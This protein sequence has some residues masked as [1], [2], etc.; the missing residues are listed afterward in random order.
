MQLTKYLRVATPII[1]AVVTFTVLFASLF[2]E[3]PVSAESDETVYY[4]LTDH[5]GS[6]DVVLDEDGNVV[7]RRDYLPYGSARAEVK[8]PAAPDT[9]QG[10]TGKEL[11][12]ETGLQ[13]YGAR[14]YDP[15]I[16]R[17]VS[18]DPWEG[19]LK[20][21]QTF[22][23]FA[24]VRNNPVRYVDPTGEK[25][26]EYQPY[27]PDNG[28]YYALGE[29]MGEYRGITLYSS[30][31]KTGSGEH[32]YQCTSWAKTFALSEYGVDMSGTGNGDAYGQQSEVSRAFN[33][34]NPDNSNM[35]AVNPNG[36][37]V[38]PREDDIIS[39]SGGTY[40][41]VGVIVEV[42]FDAKS[43]TGQVYTLEQNVSANAALF[44]QSLTRSYNEEGEIQYTVESRLNGYE[45]S[46]WAHYD[47]KSKV[48]N[49]LQ[50]NYTTTAHTPA[51]KPEEDN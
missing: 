27:A 12:E 33:Q 26:E 9:D 5:L 44:V 31:W 19:D 25:V 28:S 23:K 13:Y 14:Y 42:V 2:A 16:G 1:I 46:G 41:H 43:G 3:A 7:E 29:P 4:L 21:P 48:E 36:G 20:D 34:N 47:N 17:F 24:Y 40:G 32:P 50:P 15:S 8:G 6:V 30:A 11:D 22:N 38:M 18:V 39:W 37:S 51:T 10:F 45:V 35:Y 49:V